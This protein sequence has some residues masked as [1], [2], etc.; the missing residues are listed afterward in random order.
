MKPAE[1]STQIIQRDR[2]AE[3]L[4][5]LAVIA[6]SLDKFATEIRNL[7]RTEVF[8]VMEEFAKGQ[9]GSSAMP[10]KRNPMTSERVAGLARVIRGNVIPALENVALWHE[11]DLTQSSVERIIIPDSTTLLDYILNLFINVVSNL[12]VNKDSMQ[13]NVDKTLGLIFSQRV[14][15]AVVNKG[16]ARD[17]VYQWVQRNALKAWDEK[18]EFKELVKKDA[19]LSQYL[20]IEEIDELFDYSYHTKHVDYIFARAGI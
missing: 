19:E 3:Y 8:E 10:H 18:I 6:S 9:K 17:T 13:A 1:V 2:H 4:T 14:M 15:L 20:S 16:V 5:T 7:Q 12:Q 11:R